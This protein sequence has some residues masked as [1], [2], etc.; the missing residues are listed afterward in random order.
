MEYWSNMMMMMM[1]FWCDKYIVLENVEKLIADYLSITGGCAR[2]HYK[3]DSLFSEYLIDILILWLSQFCVCPSIAILFTFFFS[4]RWNISVHS[5]IKLTLSTFIWYRFFVRYNY[6]TGIQ[7]DIDYHHH[8]HCHHD[9][10]ILYLFF[11][12]WIFSKYFRHF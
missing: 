2:L 4:F 9:D 11:I 12:Q 5:N 8:H 3:V 1:L 6:G 10:V 7:D